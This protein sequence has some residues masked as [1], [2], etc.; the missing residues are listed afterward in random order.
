MSKPLVS[1]VIPVFNG[2][3]FLGQAIQSVLDQTY[4]PFEVIVVDDGSTDGS[5]AL[6]R[7]FPGVRVVEQENAG[8]AAARNRG[9]AVAGG[10]FLAFHD[11]DDLLP[12]AK[13]DLQVGYLQEH[14][15]LGCVLGRQEL[16]LEA[17]IEL[18]EWARLSAELARLRPDVLELG[19]IPLISMVLSASLFRGLGGFDPTY[20]HGEDADFL[21]RVRQR[22]PV[23]T[24]DSVVLLRRIHDGNLSHDVPALRLGTFRVLRDHT[25]RLRAGGDAATVDPPSE[26]ARRVDES[27]GTRNAQPRGAEGR[28]RSLE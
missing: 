11:A 26:R 6:A 23:E 15:E 20:V 7:S 19:A 3:R 9:A 8:P 5:A 2:E 13:L 14:P 21:L 28:H 27:A 4:R 17:G 12:P 1:V 10:E 24:L 16:I 22:A 18:P 25:R